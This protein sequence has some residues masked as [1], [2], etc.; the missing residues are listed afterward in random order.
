MECSPEFME[1]LLIMP[2]ARAGQQ[3]RGFRPIKWAVHSWTVAADTENVS[4]WAHSCPW[5]LAVRQP[6][7]CLRTLLR[8]LAEFLSKGIESTSGNR[9]G[10]QGNTGLLPFLLVKPLS[11]NLSF[12]AE[13]W[14][15]KDEP[16]GPPFPNDRANALMSVPEKPGRMCGDLRAPETAAVM[17]NDSIRVHTL[18]VYLIRCIPKPRPPPAAAP[19]PRNFPEMQVLRPPL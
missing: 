8:R 4:P 11:R 3:P 14:E 10:G 17:G 19:S 18:G 13:P 9:E 1:Q 2:E 7:S 15:D 12:Q 6:A 16:G 5:G